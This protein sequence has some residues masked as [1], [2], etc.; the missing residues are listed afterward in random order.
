MAI[1]QKK[2]ENYTIPE[3]KELIEKYSLPELKKIIEQDVSNFGFVIGGLE[4]LHKDEKAK[5]ASVDNLRKS[6]G[7][8]IR[9][10]Q[11]S[12]FF[13]LLHSNNSGLSLTSTITLSS[14]EEKTVKDIMSEVFENYDTM[15]SERLREY[16]EVLSEKMK[17]KKESDSTATNVILGATFFLAIVTFTTGIAGLAGWFEGVPF[18]GFS[19]AIGSVTMPVITWISFFLGTAVGLVYLGGKAMGIA[20]KLKFSPDE[21]KQI[22]LEY[23]GLGKKKNKDTEKSSEEKPEPTLEEKILT[24]KVFKGFMDGRIHEKQ[25]QENLKKLPAAPLRTKEDDVSNIDIGSSIPNSPIKMTPVNK[26]NGFLSNSKDQES[27]K[28]LAQDF[29]KSLNLKSNNTNNSSSEI[30]K[31]VPIVNPQMA[32]MSPALHFPQNRL[33]NLNPVI[34]ESEQQINQTP[35]YSIQNIEDSKKIN[36]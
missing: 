6:L 19:A 31:N 11:N 12:G 15:D 3:L 10:H 33:Q 28:I 34:Q 5:A 30:N 21:M 13:D 4:R 32:S 29:Y 17:Q 9:N 25:S 22:N 35:K 20:R 1:M 26:G 16:S 8:I 36:G 7:G 23:N 27:P 14:G 2:L 24:L 18:F